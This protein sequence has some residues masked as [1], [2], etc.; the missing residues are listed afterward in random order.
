MPPQTLLIIRHA[1]K[2]QGDWPGPG[3]DV[4]G[5]ADPKSLVVRGWQRAGA[6]AALFGSGLAST[7]YPRPTAVYAADPTS[8]AGDD[9]SQRPYETVIPL[10]SRLGLTPETKWAQG[11]EAALV[12]EL[13]T[14]TGVTLVG[15][16]HKRIVEGIL[17]A[18]VGDSGLPVPTVWDSNRFDVVLRFDRPS[19]GQSWMFRQL[20]P[21]LMSGDAA[22][23]L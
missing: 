21:Q 12:A 20:C 8:A 14:L 22:T 5:N 1:E 7:D 3:L 10:A 15:W 18:I 13:L 4:N 19:P 17:P 6:W 2:P 11:D 23:P 16:E 9:P